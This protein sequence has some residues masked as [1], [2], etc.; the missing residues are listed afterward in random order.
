MQR[1]EGY[2]SADVDNLAQAVTAI[3]F[4][5]EIEAKQKELNVSDTP[6]FANMFEE[7]LQTIKSTVSEKDLQLIAEWGKENG[8]KKI[9]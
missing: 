3:A 2:N 7:A 9:T 1:T 6:D 5:K 8:V 4:R